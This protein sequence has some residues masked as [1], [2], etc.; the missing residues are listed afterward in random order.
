MKKFKNMVLISGLAL[1]VVAAPVTLTEPA[2]AAEDNSAVST[3][4]VLVNTVNYGM[5]KNQ[6]LDLYGFTTVEITSGNKVVKMVGE[7]RVQ[8]IGSGKAVVYAYDRSGNYVIY[9][10]DVK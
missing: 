4:G 6:F 8:A 9:N 1:T 5:L 2:S 10:I 7:K 3:E